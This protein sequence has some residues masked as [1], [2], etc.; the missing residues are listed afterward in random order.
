LIQ[1]YFKNNLEP[2]TQTIFFIKIIFMIFQIKFSFLVL[3]SNISFKVNIKVRNLNIFNLSNI[4]Y[5][6]KLEFNKKYYL[7]FKMSFLII[8]I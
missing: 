2:V 8:F 7:Y 6:Q 3:D 5:I 4:N 1:H